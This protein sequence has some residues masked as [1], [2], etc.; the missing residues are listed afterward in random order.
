MFG[1]IR[2]GTRGGRQVARRLRGVEERVV[3]MDGSLARHMCSSLA[4]LTRPLCPPPPPP[5]PPPSAVVESK[6]DSATF[7]RERE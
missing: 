7:R 3:T 1:L 4:R 5:P 2:H 6:Q